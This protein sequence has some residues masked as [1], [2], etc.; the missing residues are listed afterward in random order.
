[1]G[2]VQV[3]K[4]AVLLFP[5][6]ALIIS[7]PVFIRQYHKYQAFVFWRGIMIYSFVFYMLVAYCLIILPLPDIQAVANLKTPTYNLHLFQFVT[8]FKNETPLILSKPQTYLQTLKSASF[9]QPLFNLF[10]TIPFGVYLRYYF[11]RSFKQVLVLGFLLSLFFE[12]TQLTGLYGI[13][14]RSYRLFDVDDLL[15]NTLGAIFGYVLTP[16]VTFLFPTQDKLSQK[17]GSLKNKVSLIRRAVAFVTD[18]IILGIM[19]SAIAIVLK[20]A[21]IAN[22]SIVA[23]FLAGVIL[24]VLIPLIKGQTIGKWAVKIKIVDARDGT[25]PGFWQLIFRQFELY[26][27]IIPFMTVATPYVLSLSGR[28]TEDKLTQ[29]YFLS[30]FMLFLN[31][32]FVGYLVWQAFKPSPVLFYERWSRTK[33]VSQITEEES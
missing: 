1:M 11:K 26:G 30:I 2:Y 12:L 6:L 24:F 29:L 5:I 20:M 15:L 16:A 19:A 31:L 9:I 25:K 21:Q 27:V 22:H 33:Q 13:Y 17:A 8:E 4:T 14:P 23:N 7:L 10:L 32:L 18:M 3:I 28:I